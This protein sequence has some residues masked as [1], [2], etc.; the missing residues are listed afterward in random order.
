MVDVLE[1][2]GSRMN[3]R[4]LNDEEFDA[5]LRVKMIEE[6]HEVKSAR[7][8]DELLGELADMFEVIETLANLHGFNFDEV[9]AAQLKKGKE[10]GGFGQRMFVETA[11]HPVGSFGERYCLAEPEKYPEIT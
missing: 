1:K 11:E 10:R 5:E 3:W 9:R 2:Q 4:R 7:S 6:V 8:K